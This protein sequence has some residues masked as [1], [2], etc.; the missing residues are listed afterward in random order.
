[1]ILWF[2][3]WYYI[4][5][6]IVIN[7]SNLFFSGATMYEYTCILLNY[8]NSPSCYHSCYHTAIWGWFPLLSIFPVVVLHI[9]YHLNL[10]RYHLNLG[11]IAGWFW[12]SPPPGQKSQQK[13]CTIW[14]FNSSPWKDPPFL[15]TVNH[16]FL[17]AIYT[18][19]MLV[20]TRG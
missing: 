17:W 7:Y 14:L 11:R 5:A 18:M 10:W 8:Y 15:R 13:P 3:Q 16:L 2:A 4:T 19:A 6:R 20:I 1:M 9:M 12:H